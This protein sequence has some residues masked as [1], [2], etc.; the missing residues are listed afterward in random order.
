MVTKI[1]Q[2]TPAHKV[3]SSWRMA[4]RLELIDNR[5]SHHREISFKHIR[6]EGNKLADFLA[7]MVVECGLELFAGQLPSIAS[8]DQI[9]N[10]HSIVKN[11]THQEV[12]IHPD[13]GAL[14]AHLR[15]VNS[16]PAAGFTPGQ[17]STTPRT[18]TQ[19]I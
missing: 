14:E 3:S 13:V 9:S 12:D 10:Y 18:S 8:T 2:G 7:N 1:L 16:L 17:W 5:L 11:D 15:P 19:M 6:Q 4:Q